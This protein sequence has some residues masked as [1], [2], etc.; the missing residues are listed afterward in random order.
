M[1]AE[2]WN[3]KKIFAQNSHRINSVAI[4]VKKM[5]IGKYKKEMMIGFAAGLLNGLFGAGGGC[6]VVPALEK[7]LKMDSKKAH[8]TAVGIILIISVMSAV[9][10]VLKGNFDFKIWLPVT[11]GGLAGGVVGGMLLKKISGRWLGIIFG[12]VIILTALKMIF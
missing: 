7:I 1:Q 2:I 11:G 12:G 3:I 9:I 8:G 4:L 5:K 10:Y 6:V